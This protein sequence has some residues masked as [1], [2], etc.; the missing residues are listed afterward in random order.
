LPVF[1]LDLVIFYD[2]LV[3]LFDFPRVGG[4]EIFLVIYFNWR[5]YRLAWGANALL[6][7]QA[8]GRSRTLE[9][10][11]IECCLAILG[12][13]LDGLVKVL[14]HAD[15][16]VAELAIIWNMSVAHDDPVFIYSSELL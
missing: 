9:W 2:F 12:I 6:R 13:V 7:R 3:Q 8:L 10:L 14:G 15:V 5:I 16:R 11:A 1:L 4:L